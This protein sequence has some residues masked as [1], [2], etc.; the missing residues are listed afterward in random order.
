MGMHYANNWVHRSRLSLLLLFCWGAS[1]A[2]AE[3][4][5]GQVMVVTGDARAVNAR[6]Q[7][8][9]LAKGSEIFAG[10]KIVT[11]EGGLVQLR[12]RDGG[13]LSVRPAT[14]MVID[15]FVYDE[16]NAENS[17]FL[18]SLV[19]GGFRSITGLIG[20][21]NPAGYQIRT[22][23][24]TLG[25]RG[26]DH[27]PMFIPGGGPAGSAPAGIYDKVNVGE[28]FIR[29]RF[30]ELSLKP[31][32]VGFVPAASNLP[33]QVL[34]K[35]PDFY[36]VEVKT[37][38]RDPKDAADDQPERGA[39]PVAKTTLLRPSLSVRKEAVLTEPSATT[40][41]TLDAPTLLRQPTVTDSLLAPSTTLKNTAATPAL[42]APET[43]VLPTTKLVAPLTTTVIAPKTVTTIIAPVTTPI[44]P[45][46]VAPVI[47]PVL[48][49]TTILVPKITNVPLLK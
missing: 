43:T 32:E 37:D 15:R 5:A 28:T 22:A 27:E 38:G 23:T 9:L 33:P 20:R 21:T 42:V 29:N 14:E 2:W 49:T 13:Y 35:I 34:Q 4:G 11:P 24:A 39:K 19:R 26:T 10:D 7:E 47:S 48:P 1:L 16:K 12:L 25:V 46:V 45:P 40:A 3:L 36:K 41:K 8:R 17:N 30:G 18:V 6:G 44:V 31:G